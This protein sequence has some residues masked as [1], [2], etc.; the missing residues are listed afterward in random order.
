MSDPR[1]AARPAGCSTHTTVFYCSLAGRTQ[2]SILHPL[3]QPLGTPRA[4][5]MQWAVQQNIHI[6]QPHEES[7]HRWWV[8][9]WCVT[10]ILL[11]S[12]QVWQVYTSQECQTHPAQL[13][14][15]YNHS[16]TYKYIN[17]SMNSCIF[18]VIF[19]IFTCLVGHYGSRMIVWLL[20]YVFITCK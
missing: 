18:L 16:V 17:N 11:M 13:D 19:Y 7:E 12:A 20:S 6:L 10:T 15:Q 1:V 2:A 14:L 9:E 4:M 5:F 8:R 3:P